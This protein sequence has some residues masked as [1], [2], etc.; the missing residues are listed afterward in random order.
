MRTIR[1]AGHPRMRTGNCRRILTVAMRTDRTRDRHPRVGTDR[2]RWIRTA[3]PR[4][5]LHF[6]I[7][8]GGRDRI[9]LSCVAKRVFKAR[10]VADSAS[11]FPDP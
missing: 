4:T 1:M 3:S 8:E 5:P 7:M 10:R 11:H 2:R 9:S 6:D